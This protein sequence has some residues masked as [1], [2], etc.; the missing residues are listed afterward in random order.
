FRVREREVE[1]AGAQRESRERVLTRRYAGE[2]RVERAHDRRRG[3]RVRL[4]GERFEHQR[5]AGAL[6]AE[7]AD[8][9]LELG[10][11]FVH[12]MRARL[13]NTTEPECP[14][15]LRR[16]GFPACDGLQPGL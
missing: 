8:E 14:L 15:V 4:V 16:E 2:R 3:F 12:A 9:A 7:L 13:E 10:G 6:V 5:E 11:S 1:V